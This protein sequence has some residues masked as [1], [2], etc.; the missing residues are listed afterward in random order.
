MLLP[1]ISCLLLVF[2]HTR[3]IVLLNAEA[4]FFT[5]L[6]PQDDKGRFVVMNTLE[7]L[8]EL[9]EMGPSQHLTVAKGT[10]FAA[11]A[12]L[13]QFNKAVFAAGNYHGSK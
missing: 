10:N 2:L 1:L 8:Q 12:F 3:A 5:A 4:I 7:A 6:H 11:K 13:P 9:H